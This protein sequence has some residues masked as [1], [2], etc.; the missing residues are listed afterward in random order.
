MAFLIIGIGD[1]EN[2]CK[3]GRISYRS[4]KSSDSILDNVFVVHMLRLSLP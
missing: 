3:A 2:Q 1:R 4:N